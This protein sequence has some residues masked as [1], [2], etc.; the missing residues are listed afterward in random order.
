MDPSQAFL[1]VENYTDE[2]LVWS[3]SPLLISRSC[4]YILLGLM[5]NVSMVLEGI[6]ASQEELVFSNCN[7]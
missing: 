4:I 5:K 3:V 1:T 2:L 6:L 7:L